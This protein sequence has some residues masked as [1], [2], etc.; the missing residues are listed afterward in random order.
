[1][2]SAYSAYSTTLSAPEEPSTSES[3][4][5]PVGGGRVV[6]ETVQVLKSREILIKDPATGGELSIEEALRRGIIDREKA[7]ERK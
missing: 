1:M 3:T 7:D 5:L 4:S 2:D 6:R